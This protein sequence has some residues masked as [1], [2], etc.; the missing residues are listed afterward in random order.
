MNFR[1]DAIRK[2][3]SDC[4]TYGRHVLTVGEQKFVSKFASDG[5]D[6][7]ELRPVWRDVGKPTERLGFYPVKVETEKVDAKVFN[8]LARLALKVRQMNKVTELRP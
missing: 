2:N 4:V 5:T 8:K 6:Y 3:V 1:E 7:K